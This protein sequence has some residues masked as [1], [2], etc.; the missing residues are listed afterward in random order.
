MIKCGVK[1]R[2]NVFLTVINLIVELDESIGDI[3]A[4]I[5]DVQLEIMQQIVNEAVSCENLL[6]DALEICSELDW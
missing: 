3:Y 2:E 1:I 6:K 5:I 4:D